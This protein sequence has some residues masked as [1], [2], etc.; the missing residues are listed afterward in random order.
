M[1]N[2]LL[3]INALKYFDYGYQKSTLLTFQYS[4]CFIIIILNNKH[5]TPVKLILLLLIFVVISI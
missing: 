5:D 1:K 4:D 3:L 2:T